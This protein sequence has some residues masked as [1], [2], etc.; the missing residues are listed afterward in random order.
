MQFNL[1]PN[2][3][4]NLSSLSQDKKILVHKAY[5]VQVDAISY[6]VVLLT[7]QFFVAIR[8]IALTFYEITNLVR[9]LFDCNNIL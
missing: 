2:Y 9:F 6:N 3:S 8:T 4:Q 7:I 5:V 1:I